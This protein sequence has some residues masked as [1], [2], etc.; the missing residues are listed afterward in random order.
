VTVTAPRLE[1]KNARAHSNRELNYFKMA[2]LL[3]LTKL[4]VTKRSQSHKLLRTKISLVLS[5]S[6][7]Q[8]AVLQSSV[9]QSSVLQRSVLRNS[10]LQAHPYKAQYWYCIIKLHVSLS[11]R[12]FTKIGLTRPSIGRVFKGLLKGF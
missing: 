4:S 5:S 3:S 6:V 11:K 12:S 8:N 9:L 2:R 1:G 7:L 10:I